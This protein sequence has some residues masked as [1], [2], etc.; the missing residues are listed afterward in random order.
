MSDPSPRLIKAILAFAIGTSS[1]AGQVFMPTLPAVQSDF[2]VVAAQVQLTVSIPL[3][4]VAVGTLIWGLLS[5]RFGRR[6][7]L[8]SGF[9]V[10]FAGTVASL[11]APSIAV[12]AVARVVQS[13][14][15]AAGFVVCRAVIRDLYGRERA[16][17]E[18]ASLVAIMVIAPM[19]GPLIGGTVTDF[20]GWRAV[21]AVM[22]LVVG[23]AALLI[24]LGLPETHHNRIAL[25]GVTSLFAGY[26][27]LLRSAEY[28]AYAFQSAFMVALFN[29]FMASAPYVVIVVMERSAKEY[30]FWFV[31]QTF[32]YLTGNLIVNRLAQHL[33]IDRL[34]RAALVLS[35]A[36]NFAVLAVVAAGWWNPLAI[37][38]PFL[39]MGVANGIALPNANAGA[40]SVY[41]ELAGTASG[42]LSFIQ[43]GLAAMFA[44]AAGSIQNGT[45]YPMAIFMCVCALLASVSFHAIKPSSTAG[46][47][48]IQS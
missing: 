33:G 32:G 4:S 40:V 25:P 21:F 46:R 18:L 11:L 6:A 44:Q 35:L 43:L 12:L 38:I 37:F 7:M 19:F 14:G 20:A 16:A 9:L 2:G 15:S 47:V 26:G 36:A 8:L 42:L 13:F 30:G 39:G 27:R 31:F 1:L 24:Y 22:G 3:F 17:A 28:R 23:G 41:P 5:D 45:P 48:P 34:I 29:V 10:F